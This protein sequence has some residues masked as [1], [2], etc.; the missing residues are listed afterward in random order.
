MPE[1]QDKVFEW[2]K[3]LIELGKFE[4]QHARQRF[5]DISKLHIAISGTILALDSYSLARN[6]PRI[7]WLATLVSLFG[8]FNAIA[9]W[10]QVEAASVWEARWYSSAATIENS[11]E[12]R[13]VV[14]VDNLQVWSHPDVLEKLK[15]DAKKTGASPKVYKVF[16]ASLVIFYFV[17][18]IGSV[19]MSITMPTDNTQDLVTTKNS[20]PKTPIQSQKN[21]DKS[22]NKA[23]KNIRVKP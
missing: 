19:S 22:A 2:Y 8:V 7:F 17:L 16:V 4:V 23:K 18:M 9:W 5:F 11:R 1:K 20:A 10:K 3:T 13:R 15:P 14:G 6:E 12:F 21:S